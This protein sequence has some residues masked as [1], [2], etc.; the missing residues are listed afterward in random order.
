MDKISHH[1]IDRVIRYLDSLGIPYEFSSS[2]V[3]G[4]L[5][6]DILDSVFPDPGRIIDQ[7]FLE[8]IP[9]DDRA[10][11]SLIRGKF[12]QIGMIN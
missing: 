12:F 9:R 5:S 8:G 2:Q 11:C 1:N 6:I 4:T 10:L 3:E 7:I